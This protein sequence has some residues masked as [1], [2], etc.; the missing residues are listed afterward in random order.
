VYSRTD[1][2]VLLI[3]VLDTKWKQPRPSDSVFLLM[4]LW[5]IS[6]WV[7]EVTSVIIAKRC[8]I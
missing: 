2:N 1:D 7:A 3:V 6:K 4:F 8:D 5:L